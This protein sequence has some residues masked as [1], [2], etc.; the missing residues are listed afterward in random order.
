MLHSSFFSKRVYYNIWPVWFFT[1]LLFPWVTDPNAWPQ[2]HWYTVFPIRNRIF[3]D[4]RFFWW[5]VYIPIAAATCHC[6]SKRTGLIRVTQICSSIYNTKRIYTRK[7]LRRQSE[8]ILVF[9]QLQVTAE[10]E[11]QVWLECWMHHICLYFNT[12]KNARLK[13]T[14]KVLRRY[15][16]IPAAAGHCRNRGSSLIKVKLL[17]YAFPS[18]IMKEL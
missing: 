1:V 13:N 7:P 14:Q 17:R 5:R 2:I 6:R 16:T 10:V 12:I 15:A 4:L 3:K 18:R 11:G 9:L 8:G